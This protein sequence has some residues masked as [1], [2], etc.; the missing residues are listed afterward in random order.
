MRGRPDL[1]E[2]ALR[3]LGGAKPNQ[4]EPASPNEMDVLHDILG[5]IVA[6]E[7][8][9]AFARA[10]RAIGLSPEQAVAIAQWYPCAVVTSTNIDADA[11]DYM[12]AT[13]RDFEKALGPVDFD[14]AERLWN[15]AAN[16]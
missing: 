11:V 2:R 8:I 3:L 16:S 7:R 1:R 15:T 12:E 9:V 4:A 13:E 14:E 5:Q 6:P 10:A